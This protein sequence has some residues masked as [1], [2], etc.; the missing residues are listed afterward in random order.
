MG[1]IKKSSGFLLLFIFIYTIS[2]CASLYTLED[3]FEDNE[4]NWSLNCT[5]F[6]EKKIENGKYIIMSYRKNWSFWSFA[7]VPEMIE[8]Y[9]IEA[10]ME[11]LKGRGRY[12]FIF[13]F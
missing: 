8:Q 6:V 2:S 10:D 11:L 12:G 7:P 1:I 5:E 4:N 13:N 3:S 9:S